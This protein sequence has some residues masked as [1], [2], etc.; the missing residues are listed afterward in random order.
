MFAGWSREAGMLSTS[1]VCRSADE[2]AASACCASFKKT[3]EEGKALTKRDF[4]LG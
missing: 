3:A 2:V 1:I 4:Q